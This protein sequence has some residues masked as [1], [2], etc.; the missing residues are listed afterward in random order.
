M[1]CKKS[2]FLL[3]WLG[4]VWGGWRAAAAESGR[5][6]AVRLD[7]SG[8]VIVTPPPLGADEQKAVTVLCEEIQKR[9]G[10]R[11]ERTLQWPDCPRRVI[12]MGLQSQLRQFAGPFAAELEKTP[13][14]GREGFFLAVE[15]QPR[16][17]IL[18]VAG[19]SRGLLYG[20]GRLLRKMELARDSV[21]VP[22]GVRIVTAPKFSLRGHQLGY[23]PINNTYSAWSAGQFEQYIR[24]L[25]LFGANSIEILPPGADDLPRGPQM[26]TPPL[27]MMERLSAIIDS[28]GL[29]VWVWYPNL[30]KDY[31][32]APPAQGKP[33]EPAAAIPQDRQSY[34]RWREQRSVQAELAEREDVFRRLRRIDNLLVPGG[35]PGT[36]HP[37]V[38]FPWLDQ[39][40]AVLHKYHPRAK[41]WVSPQGV[42][43][44]EWLDSFCKHVNK[45]PQWLG[46]V[47]F[48]S[49][50]AMPLPEFRK[51]ID[52]DIPIRHYPDITHN[53][54]CGFPVPDWDL[55]FALTLHRE[56][57][58][59]RPLAMKAIHNLHAGDTCGS[60]AYSDGIHDDVNKFVWGDQDWDP[61]TPVAE[62]LRDYCRL[63]ISPTLAD[64]LAQGLLAEEKNWEGPLA[65][66]AQVKV[67]LQQW[68]QLEKIA[69]PAVQANYRFQMGLLRAYYDAYIQRRLIYET[70]LE[71]SALDVLRAASA[72]AGSLAAVAK[73]KSYLER[74]RT[75][76]AAADYKQ[77]CL[78][79]A[80]RLYASIGAQFT[81]KRHGYPRNRGAF[82]DGIDEPLNNAAWLAAEFHRLGQLPE[83][84]ARLAAIE[85]ILNRTNPGPG[86]F[87]DDFATAASRRR[88][89]GSVAWAT[90]PGALKSPLVVFPYDMDAPK[91]HD[92][93][94][95]WRRQASGTIIAGPLR[96]A[97]EQLDPQASYRVRATFSGL[98]NRP[99]ALLVNGR[100]LIRTARDGSAVQE[101]SIPREATAGGRL[102]L[103]WLD[104]GVVAEMWLIKDSP[105]AAPPDSRLKKAGS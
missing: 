20:V 68:Q 93:P 98:W 103:K 88:I 6:A 51:T 28:Y 27:E 34:L 25:A 85:R 64:E 75:E 47:A 74:A 42:H 91:Y 38:L 26:K 105:R 50:V 7:F 82:I 86:G 18:I 87:Y 36:L 70:E 100:H 66:N 23:R 55:A 35:D 65:V 104:G 61:S 67:T 32:L 77:K 54:Y 90:D 48:S 80:D 22:A 58:N 49:W 16:E 19:D 73:A 3:A 101:F 71:A 21:L 37:D 10:T 39:V 97:Y 9:S 84:P 76:P 95:A 4:I 46:G 17:A 56:S 45:K 89:V 60:I 59:P 24:E 43:G 52:K 81:M 29:D 44:R 99:W 69:S 11:L 8:A 40:A 62:T 53:V 15:H 41:I 30:A 79:L 5:G 31:S 94:L 12:A 57:I 83:E 2:L 96:I 1:M 72:A 33:A 92:V 78:D 13:L 63:F 14:P 102:E